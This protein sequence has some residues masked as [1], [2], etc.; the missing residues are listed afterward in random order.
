MLRVRACPAPGLASRRPALAAPYNGIKARESRNRSAAA[1]RRELWDIQRN[2]I[3]ESRQW[4]LGA[5][6]RLD[7]YAI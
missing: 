5:S 4:E 1:G 6:V 2:P 3:G 7:Y